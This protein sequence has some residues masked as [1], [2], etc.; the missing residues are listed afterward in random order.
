MIISNPHDTGIFAGF[1][2]KWKLFRSSH[3]EIGYR[4]VA[5]YKKWPKS[6]E[7]PNI[8]STAID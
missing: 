8:G 6:S 5:E 2:E 4:R 3:L 1:Q 7:I